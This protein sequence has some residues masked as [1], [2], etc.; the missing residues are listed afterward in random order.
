MQQQFAAKCRSSNCGNSQLQIAAFATANGGGSCSAEAVVAAA[1]PVG[2]VAVAALGHT[3]APHQQLQ[4]L[5]CLAACERQW[6]L[7]H[8]KCL[9]ASETAAAGGGMLC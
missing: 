7:Q 1:E 8:V 2:A 4:E 6:Q 5:K 3:G 9:A